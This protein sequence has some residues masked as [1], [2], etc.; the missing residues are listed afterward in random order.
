MTKVDPGSLVP[1]TFPRSRGNVLYRRT[2]HGLVAGKWPRKR[3]K[4]AE[5]GNLYR[6]LEFGLVASW[7]ST[8]EPIAF[9]TAIEMVKDTTY[10]PRDYLMMCAYGTYY[11]LQFEDGTIWPKYRQVTVNAQLTLDQVTETHG[12]LMYRAPIG[13]LGLNIG[14]TGQVLTVVDGAPEWR[15][16]EGGSAS[17]FSGYLQN[18]RTGTSTSAYAAKGITIQPRIDMNHQTGWISASEI[19]GATYEMQLWTLSG[20]NLGTKLA[21]STPWT[22]SVT[23]LITRTYSLD[24]DIT[25]TTGTKYLI[26]LVRT[27]ATDTTNNGASAASFM[28]TSVP[29]IDRPEAVLVPRK[30][31]ASGNAITNVG[32]GSQIDINMTFSI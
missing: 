9:R 3:G 26:L 12:A 6:Q 32:T 25:L 2:K 1:F 17:T 22:A 27:D 30:N 19:N 11:D 13:W 4:A 10:L 5:G 20:S 14:S 21:S 29:L 18:Y 24:S 28:S 7:A 8:P 23:Q 31:P 15:P 16:P